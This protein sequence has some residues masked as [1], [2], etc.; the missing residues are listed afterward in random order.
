MATERVCQKMSFELN[1]DICGSYDIIETREGFV[2]RACGIVLEIQKLEYHRPYNDDIVQYAKVSGTTQIGTAKE[3]FQHSNSAQL[4]KMN[5]L[6][7]I[8]SNEKSVLEKARI[9]ISRIFNC[10]NLP[11]SFKEFV[12]NT[13]KKIR[14]ALKS[15]TKYR[16]FEKL[17]PIAI[18]FT[19]KYQNVSI[20]EV[21]LLEVSKIS[22]KDFNAFKLQIR[23][24]LPEYDERDR[25]EYI[26]K[27][28]YAVKENLQL[29]MEFYYLSKKILHKFWE[30]IKNTKD[31]VIAGL[32]SSISILCLHE[33]N[34]IPISSICNLLNIK[35]STIQC[36]VKKKIFERYKVPG[37]ISL[38]KS[39]NLLKKIIAKIG[40]IESRPDIIEI[41]LGNAVQ[42][43]DHF[44]NIDFYFYALKD[45]NFNYNLVFLK[46]CDYS[47]PSNQE[48]Y[49]KLSKDHLFKTVELEVPRFLIGKGPP[50]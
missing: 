32:V 13:F 20:N 42:V 21:N 24:F 34:K 4:G 36:Q 33:H 16:S 1:C 45:I 49:N 30:S 10:L 25:Q 28:V 6:Q 22:K 43:F 8:K 31:N 26:L 40:L 12:F 23:N 27:K 3:R 5:K 46:S 2:C 17:V 37:F 14:G 39:S 7:S 19:F 41:K 9:E 18:Y 35:M 15:G 48:S 47:I 44:N 29:S 38:I 11:E 50:T